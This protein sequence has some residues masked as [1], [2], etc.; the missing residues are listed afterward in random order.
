MRRRHVRPITAIPEVA[1]IS[2]FQLKLETTTT[3]IDRLLLVPR[4]SPWKISLWEAQEGGEPITGDDTT[5][6]TTGD[7]TNLTNTEL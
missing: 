7:V 4:Q 2:N 6:T 5:D 3:I 1:Q